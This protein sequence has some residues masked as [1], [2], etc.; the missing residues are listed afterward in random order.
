[1]AQRT[2]VSAQRVT[3]APTAKAATSSL[4]FTGENVVTVF[5]VAMLLVGAGWLL[6]PR[7]RG[8]ARE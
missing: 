3:A 2:S 5:L 4:P 8:R 1:V 6:R 7:N